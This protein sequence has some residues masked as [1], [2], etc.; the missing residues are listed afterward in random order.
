VGYWSGYSI[1]AFDSGQR[2]WT[3]PWQEMR[4]ID[5]VEC[6]K[7]MRSGDAAWK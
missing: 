4:E 5:G 2:V 7:I 1:V 6:L 3:G